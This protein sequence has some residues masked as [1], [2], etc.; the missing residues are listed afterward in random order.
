MG[1]SIEYRELEGLAKMTISGYPDEEYEDGQEIEVLDGDDAFEMMYNPDN[2]SQEF[3]NNYVKRTT[4]GN[5]GTLV[6]THTEP[7]SIAFDF[8]FDATCASVSGSSNITDRILK[9]K[10]TDKVI[11]HFLGIA[12]RRSGE[13]HQ[14]NFLKLRWGDFEFRGILESA[15]VTHKLFDTDG[16]PIRS[17]VNCS[18]RK[19]TSLKEQAAEERRNSPDMTHYRLVIEGDTLPGIAKKVYGDASLYLELARVNRLINFRK[20]EAGERLILPPIDKTAL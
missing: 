14:P 18:F 9:D 11:Q 12:Y 6:F 4:Q 19:H 7:E 10:R 15:T 2:Y 1:D 5:T 13:S 20:L 3:K 17:T 8:L 16:Y